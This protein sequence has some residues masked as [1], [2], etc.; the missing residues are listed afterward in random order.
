MIRPGA[1]AATGT[2]SHVAT[3]ARALLASI[4]SNRA[5]PPAPFAQ[6]I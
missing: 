2:P 6:I 3:S 5:M 4:T 1:G